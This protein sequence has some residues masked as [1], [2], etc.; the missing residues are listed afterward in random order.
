MV[1]YQIWLFCGFFKNVHQIS[2]PSLR[3]SRSFIM[4]QFLDRL[5]DLGVRLLKM[6]RLNAREIHTDRDNIYK[7][8]NF[9]LKSHFISWM[10]DS[11]LPFFYLSV[12]WFRVFE[13]F[14][15]LSSINFLRSSLS[16]WF[17]QLGGIFHFLFG[18]VF[19]ILDIQVALDQ[20]GNWARFWWIWCSDRDL[21]FA[22]LHSK[23]L[24][25]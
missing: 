17:L 4:Y 2:V 13:S 24:E 11:L 6:W 10:V 18:F 14:R 20:L 3:H 23:R 25:L 16:T 12:L 7:A 15:F 21:R 22:F 1:P 5:D 8:E 19:I 9:D